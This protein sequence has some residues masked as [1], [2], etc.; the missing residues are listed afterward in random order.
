VL[1]EFPPCSTPQDTFQ[2]FRIEQRNTRHSSLIS[3]NIE[4][5]VKVI[6]S[7]YKQTLKGT[8]GYVSDVSDSNNYKLEYIFIS[9][10]F[11]GLVKSLLREHKNTSAKIPV[12]PDY[13][14]R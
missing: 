4:V 6:G 12:Y 10:I 11:S 5:S 9:A 14:G 7:Q 13:F 3:E 1:E 2:V 8:S